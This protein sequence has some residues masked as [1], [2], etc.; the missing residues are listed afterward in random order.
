MFP[1]QRTQHRKLLEKITHRG[2]M[3]FQK[4]LFILEVSFPDAHR[5]L[6]IKYSGIERSLHNRTFQPISPSSL[7]PPQP[8]E[9]AVAA[10][11]IPQPVVI[12]PFALAPALPDKV[13]AV[14]PVSAVD[15][16]HCP[17]IDVGGGL[18][19]EFYTKEVTPKRNISVKMADKFNTSEKISTYDMKSSKRGLLFLVNIINFEK[20]PRKKRNGATV[21]RDNLISLFR[22][23]NFQIIYYE[24]ITKAV[25]I[26]N[27]NDSHSVFTCFQLFFSIISFE[28]LVQQFFA[29]LNTFVTSPFIRGID[30][31]VFGLLSHGDEVFGRTTVDF[32]DDSAEIN[33]I[34]AK[35]SNANCM[36]LIGKPKIFL[37]PFCR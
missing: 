15:N 10:V 17:P 26:H 21:D 13:R 22:Q 7:V 12:P 3:A 33:D 11:A 30:C 36:K 31:L 4:F 34:I 19:L 8:I 27:H 18:K 20:Q 37:F 2:P 6:E 25:R 16:Y 32:C 35:F 5:L 28:F 1:D 29:L 9:L 14:A 23:M 24:D